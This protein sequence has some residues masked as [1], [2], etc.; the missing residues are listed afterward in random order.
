MNYVHVRWIPRDLTDDLPHL[1]VANCRDLLGML[2]R[3]QRSHFRHIVTGD[4]NWFSF[5]YQHSRQWTVSR[6]AVS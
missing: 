1:S 3:M 6:D 2:E 4:E 5:E